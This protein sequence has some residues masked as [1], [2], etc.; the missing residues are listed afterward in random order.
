MGCIQCCIRL[1]RV[2]AI[3]CFLYVLYKINVSGVQRRR[4]PDRGF[5]GL[6]LLSF[7]FDGG[8][9]PALWWEAAQNDAIFESGVCPFMC[10]SE[11]S[12]A[13]CHT[14]Y[15]FNSISI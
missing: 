12:F 6:R 1:I 14:V 7:R 15:T 5:G 9:R 11:F 2:V 3:A 13:T 4:R 10:T 8:I